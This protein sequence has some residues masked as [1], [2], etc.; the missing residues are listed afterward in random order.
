MINLHET[1][2]WIGSIGFGLSGAPQAYQS[3]KDKHSNGITWGLV[4]LW[5]IGE[6]FS[7]AYVLPDRLWPLVFNY[8]GN[9]ILVAIITYYKMYPKGKK[10]ENKRTR[11]RSTRNSKI[12]RVVRRASNPVG[13]SHVNRIRNSGSN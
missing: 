4:Y 6:W 7:L 12:Q 2:G 5:M 13:D 1:I 3:W 11:K 8:V 10:R 9:I